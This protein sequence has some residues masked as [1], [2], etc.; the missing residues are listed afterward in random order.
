MKKFSN[1]IK[2]YPIHATIIFTLSL[3]A[4]ILVITALS[5]GPKGSVE[6]LV[7]PASAEITINGKS[8]RNGTFDFTP[9][10]YKVEIKKSGFTPKSL[11]LSVTANTSQKLY[12]YLVQEDG[13][14]I[15]YKDHL[16]DDLILTK[17]G[18]YEADLAEKSYQKVHPI[19]SSLP[20][21]IASYDENY[22]Y[23][24]YRI[25]GG[26]F[27]TCKSGFCL[28]ITD[29]T[30]GNYESALNNIK[31]LGYNPED[32]E[33]LYEFTPIIPLSML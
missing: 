31:N 11:I 33:I 5:L 9:G 22:N 20:L 13:E 32:F 6:I 1:F 12:A 10:D 4:I 18:D 30:G 26:S 24:E 17:I 21:I 25:D 28:K 2:K 16:S 29:V 23:T 19:I 7:A 15:W 14:Y 3:F 27:E 8:Y